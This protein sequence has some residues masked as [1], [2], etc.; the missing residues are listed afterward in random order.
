[1]RGGERRGVMI[2]GTEIGS[3]TKTDI[4]G[5]VSPTVTNYSPTYAA[6]LELEPSL[7]HPIYIF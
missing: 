6:R 7:R 5:Y 2:E 1:M 3:V 4:E